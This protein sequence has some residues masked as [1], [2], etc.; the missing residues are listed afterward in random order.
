M[1]KKFKSLMP[2]VEFL[3]H[4]KRGQRET[5]LTKAKIAD[6]KLYKT[7]IANI[8]FK[9]LPIATESI[10]KLKCYRKKIAHICEKKTSIKTV[11]QLLIEKDF[12]CKFLQIVLPDITSIIYKPRPPKKSIVD[13]SKEKLKE[14]KKKKSVD[15]QDL[16]FEHDFSPKREEDKT[17]EPQQEETEETEETEEEEQESEGPDEQESSEED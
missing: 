2:E 10:K 4:L 14:E 16:S 5:Y 6:I 8:F 7:F 12:F 15:E 17:E 9:N 11:R 3:S 13:T 1:S